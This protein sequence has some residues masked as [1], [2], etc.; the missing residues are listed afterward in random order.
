MSV[1]EAAHSARLVDV[2][3]SASDSLELDLQSIVELLC[4][5]ERGVSSVYR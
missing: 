2:F 1:K 3:S 5:A 4:A